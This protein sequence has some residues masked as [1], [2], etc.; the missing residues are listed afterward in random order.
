VASRESDLMGNHSLACKTQMITATAVPRS[1]TYQT[2][3]PTEPARTVGGA[4]LTG[5][6]DHADATSFARHDNGPIGYSQKAA[7]VA[8]P[9]SLGSY[10]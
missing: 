4:G 6:A 3:V 2:A 5:C 8:P 1:R 10:P 9:P 7:I